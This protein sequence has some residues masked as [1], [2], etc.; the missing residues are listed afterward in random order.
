MTL[1]NLIIESY[2]SILFAVGA[3]ACFIFALG[4]YLI[5]RLSQRR[6]TARTIN[7][8]GASKKTGLTDK[9]VLPDTAHDVTSIAG[10]DPMATQLDL[11]RAYI[12]TGKNQF[13]KIILKTVLRE[14]SIAHQEEA[15]R[16]LGSI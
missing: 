7:F 4:T 12:E 15:Q 2:S 9:M 1:I 3:V 16:L 6:D 5:V 13:A 14:G 10:D 8:A 11:A